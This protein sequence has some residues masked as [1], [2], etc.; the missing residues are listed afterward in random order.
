M[1]RSKNLATLCRI[2]F[3]CSALRGEPKDGMAKQG[4]F[5]GALF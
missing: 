1:D 4:Q 2:L 3:S 5:D